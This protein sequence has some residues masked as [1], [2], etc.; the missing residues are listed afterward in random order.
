MTP[1]PDGPPRAVRIAAWRVLMQIVEAEAEKEDRSEADG[2]EG[3]AL[4]VDQVGA[5]AA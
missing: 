4:V 2:K 5:R 3:T 1:Q